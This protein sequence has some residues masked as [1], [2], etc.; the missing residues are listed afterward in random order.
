MFIAMNDSSSK[1]QAV[2]HPLETPVAESFFKALLWIVLILQVAVFVKM[3][4][5]L[6]RGLPDRSQGNHWRH[7]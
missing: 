7:G 1:A 5:G 4:Q 2:R 6:V 3:Y